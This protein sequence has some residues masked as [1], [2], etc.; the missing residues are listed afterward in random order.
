[1]NYTYHIRRKE[2]QN[3]SEEFQIMMVP[4]GCDKERHHI[5]YGTRDTIEQARETVK[6]LEGKN[7]VKTE[8]VE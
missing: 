2:F 6:E 7:V 8:W 1:M 5:M 4:Y 3:G